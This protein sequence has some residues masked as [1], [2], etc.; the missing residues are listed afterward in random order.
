MRCPFCGRAELQRV[1]R[2]VP[3]ALNGRHAVVAGVS[4]DF[5]EACGEMILA[6][7]EADRIGSAMQELKQCTEQRLA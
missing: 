4:G 6:D 3:L 1:V 5:C 2:D 7:G